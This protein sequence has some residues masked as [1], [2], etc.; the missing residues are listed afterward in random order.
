MGHRIVKLEC[1]LSRLQDIPRKR[2]PI[3]T[4]IAI[5]MDIFAE[6]EEHPNYR[7]PLAALLGDL[8]K[9]GELVLPKSKR[10][11]E[12]IGAPKLP[13]WVETVTCDAISELGSPIAW[14][15]ECASLAAQLKHQA[16]LQDLA[17]INAY[18][19]E[20][21][22]KLM[23]IPYR[24][25]A[26][27][28]FGDEHY[29]DHMVKDEHLFQGRLSLC[30]LYAFKANEP[31]PYERPPSF[32][33][34]KPLLIVENHHSFASFVREN[35]VQNAFSAICFS[36]GHTL[37]NREYSLD[38]IG[39]TLETRKYMYLGDI[40]ARGISMPVEINA[41]RKKRCAPLLEPATPFYIWL[42]RNGRPVPAK[43]R[44]APV[45]MEKVAEWFSHD[46]FI[47]H[48]IRD[49]LSKNERIPQEFLGIEE[50]SQLDI[51]C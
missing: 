48:R 9:K 24:E 40:D 21:R 36:S 18:L 43:K 26:L 30:T 28:I 5:F 27:K 7:E 22:G 41:M 38:D 14:L 12:K 29:L 49:L 2:I 3:G 50:L 42:L 33:T 44:Q 13:E 4:V 19:I 8:E 45:N 11:W 6:Y 39:N 25:R 46:E 23:P 16:Q 1:F 51:S 31:M 47:I 17:K 15:P 37:A 34:G 35:A 10:L 20:N 32:V